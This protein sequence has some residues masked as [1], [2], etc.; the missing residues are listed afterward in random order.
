MS[1]LE[2]R[3]EQRPLLVFWETTKACPLACHHCR[4]SARSARDDTELDTEE[5]FRLVEDLRPADRPRTTLIL[6]GG[7]CLVRPDL[8]EILDHARRFDVPVGLAPSVSP[9]L[10]GATAQRLHAAGVRSISISLDGAA[11]R[12]HD[13]IRRI[14]G[15]YEATVETIDLLVR[16]GFRVQVNTT[17]MPANVM[18][19]PDIAAVLSWH[20]VPIWEVFFLITTG[21]GRTLTELGPEEN[22]AVCH[23]LVDAAGYGMTVRTVEAPFFRR[24][25]SWRSTGAGKPA[26]DFRLHPLYEQLRDRLVS[27]LGEPRGRIDAPTAATRD[28]NGVVFVAHD[29][30]VYPSG[31]LPL[32]VGNVR[33]RS[34]LR[35]YRESALLRALRR[36]EFA[37]ACGACDFRLLCGGSRARAYSGGDPLGSDP[38]CLHAAAPP[39]GDAVVA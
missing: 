21:R 8:F 2:R 25:R 13:G 6:T 26:G 18:E 24:V 30:A 35:I 19:L 29:G 7:D 39:A 22:E 32:R 37:G 27:Q 28:G 1:D 15:H 9:S 38:G 16:S 12:T 4:A 17:V 31:F 36:A 14:D 11:P 10:T 33:E 23:F 3:F 5:A 34:L 20:S